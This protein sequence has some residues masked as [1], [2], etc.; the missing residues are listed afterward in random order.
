MLLNSKEKILRSNFGGNRTQKW[1]IKLTDF[2]Y[3]IHS[4]A[5]IIKK[6]GNCCYIAP[7]M[8]PQDHHMDWE[9]LLFGKRMDIWALG[10]MT[11]WMLSGKYPFEIENED[12]LGEIQ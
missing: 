9:K 1:D 5:S 12:N 10:I 6:L 7:Q 2:G 11:Y 4:D 8:L 3:T